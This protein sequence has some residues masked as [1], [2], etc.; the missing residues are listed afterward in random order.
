M[1]PTPPSWPLRALAY[2]S[3]E[4]QFLKLFSDDV[5]LEFLFLVL[6]QED[7]QNWHIATYL[8]ALSIATIKQPHDHFYP[9]IVENWGDARLFK[10]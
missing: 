1:E 2:K 10:P 3:K 9:S 7:D 4:T 8:F 5:K 6:H